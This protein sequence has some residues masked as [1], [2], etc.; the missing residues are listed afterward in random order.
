MIK[1]IRDAYNAN[2]SE[3]TYQTFLHDIDTSFDFKVKFKI[4]E[5]PVFIPKA[6]KQ[7]LI[8]A[9]DDIM[10]VIDKPN[11][12]E[13]TDGAF[14]D[15]NTIVPNEDEHSKFIQLDFGI[16][17]DENGELTPKLI[18]LQGFPSL[19][20]FQELVG[21]KYREHF[22]DTIPKDFFATS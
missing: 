3:E 21:R 17:K 11:F 12:K 16:C 15:A 9:C 4:A 14:F 22:G 8:D 1:T 20:F 13:L 2:F 7:K 10:S 18:E 19:Y 6:L 5:T